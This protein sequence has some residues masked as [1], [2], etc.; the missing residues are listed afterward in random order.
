[1]PAFGGSS[2]R[3]GDRSRGGRSLRLRQPFSATSRKKLL[4]Q[5]SRSAMI[6]ATGSFV[7]S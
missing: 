6:A 7:S 1:M 2:L 3:R 5:M 4:R